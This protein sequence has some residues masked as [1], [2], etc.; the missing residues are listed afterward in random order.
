MELL[1]Q[2][3]RQDESSNSPHSAWKCQAK[4]GNQIA[5]MAVM[6]PWVLA[7]CKYSK[8]RAIRG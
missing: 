5:M 1:Q 2:D 6:R 8:F 3:G 7:A 4:G